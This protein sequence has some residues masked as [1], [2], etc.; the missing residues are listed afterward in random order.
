M[1]NLRDTA[2][3]TSETQTQ[4]DEKLIYL[5]FWLCF[6]TNE[7]ASSALE[8]GEALASALTLLTHHRG[9]VV[10]QDFTLR[11][12]KS[13]SLGD[14]PKRVEF[15]RGLLLILEREE[16]GFKYLLPFTHLY[17]ND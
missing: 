11:G 3:S 12:Q 4:V 17:H 1:E 9:F 16:R 8:A 14:Q 7:N 6:R 13:F 5:W 15:I 2:F 10:G